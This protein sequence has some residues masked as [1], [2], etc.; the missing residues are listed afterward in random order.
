MD[1]PG[2]KQY[3]FSTFSGVVTPSVLAILGAVMYFILPKVVGSVG[4]AEMLLILFLAH[5]ITIATA[6]SIASTTTNMRVKEGG[7]YY[8]VSRSLGSELGGS[9]GIQ[10]YLAQTISIS[11]YTIAFSTAVYSI[12]EPLG[13]AVNKLLLSI[14]S[15]VFFF[16]LV[17][18][19]ADFVIKIQFM[20]LAA[21]LL[22]LV[23][24]FLGP[25]TSS[26]DFVSTGDLPFWVAFTMFFPAVTGIGAGVGMSGDLKTPEKSIVRGTFSSIIFTMIVYILL[27]F[28]ISAAA[29]P[30]QLVSNIY[31]MYD[32][33]VVP[34]LVLLGVLMAT[35]SSALSSF[36]AAPRA[37]RAIVKDRIFPK[38]FSILS[39]GIGDSPEPRAAIILSFII[40]LAV[41]FLGELD[42]VATLV[43][44]FFLN[45]YGWINAAAF[46][47]K[48]SRNPSFRPSFPSPS[49]VNAY[50]MLACY[51]VMYLFNPLLMF[52]GIMFQVVVFFMIYKGRRS[53]NIEGVWEGLW[54]QLYKKVSSRITSFTRSR[55]NWRPISVA[56]LKNPEGEC[57]LTSVL[58]WIHA[59][60][61]IVKV[62]QIAQEGGVDAVEQAGECEVIGEGIVYHRILSDHPSTTVKTLVQGESVGNLPYNTVFLDYDDDLDI[63]GIVKDLAGSG[64]NIILLRNANAFIQYETIDVWWEENPL[65]SFMLIVSY[66]VATSR[67]WQADKLNI[68]VLDVVEDEGDVKRLRNR[69][70]RLVENA[71]LINTEIDVVQGSRRSRL[72]KLSEKSHDTDLVIMKLPTGKIGDEKEFNKK[73]K[74]LTKD[75]KLALLVLVDEDADFKI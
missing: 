2:K 14:A 53:A 37:L 51:I 49:L 17:Y 13:F 62:Y 34:Q 42:F 15:L 6:F 7:L 60:T 19:G 21:V 31:V 33:A 25:N 1:K 18:R 28:K 3:N 30:H 47:E 70:K 64:K 39:H 5:S 40:A 59:N 35:F 74:A 26:L 32:L 43:G 8:L 12:L 65:G 29:T 54:F 69:V 44:I 75:L 48:I 10:L 63:H 24:I 50:G 55:K 45:V 23:S 73:V 58:E 38:R 27:S 67:Q 68:R 9:I 4:L 36:M 56:F 16:L 20:V 57:V 71:R 72:K 11:F 61:S 46:L 52:V 66:L 22:S 41:L